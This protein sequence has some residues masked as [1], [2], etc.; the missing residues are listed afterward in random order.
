M[1]IIFVSVT[2]NVYPEKQSSF[3]DKLHFD[4]R[5]ETKFKNYFLF[6]IAEGFI[7]CKHSVKYLNCM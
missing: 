1:T 2:K 6:N 3:G 5:E 7:K 4:R